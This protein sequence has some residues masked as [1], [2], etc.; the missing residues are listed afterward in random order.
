MELPKVSPLRTS[1]TRAAAAALLL[2]SAAACSADSRATAPDAPGGERPSS[3]GR[4][5]LDLWRWSE[6]GSWPDGELP[7]AGQAVVVPRGRRMLLDV[8]PPALERLEV[9]GE[10][11]FADRDLAIT[12]GQILVRGV[13]RAGTEQRPYAHRGTITLTGEDPGTSDLRTKAIAV[14]SGGRLEL[15]GTRRSGWTRLAANAPAGS[16]QL[17]LETPVDWRAGDRIAVA[18]T[19]FEASEAE[20]VVIEDVR[21]TVVTLAAP[22]RFAH[23]GELQTVA[24][25]ALDERAEVGLLSR[26]LVV[27]G[28]DA[29]ARTGFGGHIIVFAG[30]SAQIEHTE[31][32]R[33]GQTGRLARYPIHWHMNGSTSGQ[34]ARD[35]SIWRTFSRCLT[36]HG[37]HDVTVSRNV[38]YDHIGHGYFLEDGIE[39]RNTFE[40]NLGMLTRVPPAGRRLIASDATPATFWIT[41]PDNTFR[42]NHAAGSQGFGFWFG[43]PEHPTGLSATTAVWPTQTPLREFRGNVAHSNGH[44]GLHVDDGPTTVGDGL[45][46]MWYRPRQVPG[47]ANSPAVKADFRDF[48]AWKNAFR[49]AWIRGDSMAMTGAVIADNRI[50]VIFASPSAA[51]ERALVVGESDNR[52]ASPNPTYPIHGFEYYDGVVHASD[53]TFANFVPNGSRAAGALGLEFDNAAIVNAGNWAKG[54]RFVNA[55]EVAF[56]RAPTADGDKGT[57]FQDRDG[58]VTGFAGGTVVA[59]NPLLIDASCTRRA[60]WNAAACRSRYVG[61]A[62]TAFAHWE[63]KVAPLTV[64]RDDGASARLNGYSERWVS[65]PVPTNRRY[66]LAF[67]GAA[68]S[69]TRIGYE[70]LAEGDWVTVSFPYAYPHFEMRAGQGYEVVPPS[71][72][73]AALDASARTTW[74]VDRAAGVLHVKIVG[75]AGGEREGAVW[76]QPTK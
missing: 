9:D 53:V 57:V 27:R 47:A 67:P 20:D 64:R 13:L 23:W 55:N 6:P 19:S 44:S 11:T 58:S 54:L 43:L 5:A 26:N 30:G 73:L 12:A 37:T 76:A 52:T 71:A 46:T 40:G 4:D 59:D 75:R 22:L 39:T 10:L 48:T 1:G 15:H 38:C 36:V 34:Y 51:F 66:T 7:K 24:G 72:S 65:T 2:L 74:F 49:G 16:R 33:V 42:A 17:V 3:I 35:N 56:P 50:G 60:E 25:Q 70:H 41:N 61:L 69:G 29:S 68:P 32:T 45:R 62:I 31:L 8:S 14:M 63:P 28:D 18:S 21:G